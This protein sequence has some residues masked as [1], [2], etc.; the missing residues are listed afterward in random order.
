MKGRWNGRRIVGASFKIV[1]DVT[2]WR[3]LPIYIPMCGGL[4][5]MCFR[6]WTGWEYE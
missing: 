1:L 5:W 6:T 3:W 4:H 2:D